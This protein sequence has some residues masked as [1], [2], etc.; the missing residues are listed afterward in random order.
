MK[1]LTLSPETLR[2]DSFPTEALGTKRM[3]TVQ[4]YITTRPYTCPECA[5]SI[6]PT[7]DC[8]AEELM[9]Y[10]IVTTR[11]QRTCPECAN[12]GLTCD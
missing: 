5:N 9:A 6:Y 7:C 11:P 3:G 1:K 10:A 4:G 12:T 8:R 2:V